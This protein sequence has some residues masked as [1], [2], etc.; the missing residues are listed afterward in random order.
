MGAVRKQTCLL[1]FL[2]GPLTKY[3][4][5]LILE[6]SVL[7]QNGKVGQ[8]EGSWEKIGMPSTPYLPLTLHVEASTSFPY[9]ELKVRHINFKAPLFSLLG[10]VRKSNKVCK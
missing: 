6:D 5:Q 1:A 7:F 2:S 9:K 8:I 4:E 10:W 3:V